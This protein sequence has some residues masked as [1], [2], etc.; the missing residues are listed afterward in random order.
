MALIEIPIETDGQD[1]EFNTTLNNQLFW[2]Q[3]KY[4]VRQ[5][6]WVFHLLDADKVPIRQGVPVVTGYPVLNRVQDV[7]APLGQ[8]M[9]IDAAKTGLPP[10]YDELGQRVKMVY[11]E[12]E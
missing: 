12:A 7:R 3:F 2:F 5:D 6:R 9:F 10:S 11:Q 8:L 4:N 1:F